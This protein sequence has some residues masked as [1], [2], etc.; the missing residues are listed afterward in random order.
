MNEKGTAEE[1]EK[2]V[3]EGNTLPGIHPPHPQE[4]SEKGE[5]KHQKY[6]RGGTLTVLGTPRGVKG[7]GKEG[8]GEG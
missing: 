3:G 7:L 1:W 6:G 2:L 5:K 4:K 8:K